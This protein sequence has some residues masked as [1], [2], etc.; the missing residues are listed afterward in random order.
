MSTAAEQLQRLLAFLPQIA[1]GNRHPVAD[2]AARLGVDA[3]TVLKDLR[4]LTER[5]GDPP[6]WVEKVQLYIEAD[7]VSMEATRHFLRPMRLSVDEW[8]AIELGL[9]M[10]RLE[11]APDDRAVIDS[12]LEKVRTLLSQEPEHAGDERA[13]TLG[14]DRH[15]AILPRLREALKSRRRV[16]IAYVKGSGD[17]PDRRTICP[18]SFAVEQ[19]VWYLVAH[20]ERSDDLRIFRLDRVVDL[21]VLDEQF[22]RTND[23]PMDELFA[24]GRAFV[25]DAPEK[26]RVRYSP[27][28]ARWIGEREQGTPNPD[29]SLEVEYPLADPDWAVRHALQ[30]GAEAEVLAPVAIRDAIVERLKQA[31]V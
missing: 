2:V 19:G 4:D 1:D 21:K 10:L 24:D 15:L 13:A 18:F 16:E 8:R 3:G 12:A 28:V 14:A 11:R 31:L 17:A 22:D 6:G 27:R 25:G 26:L 20:C 30:Y 7:Q 29:G 9:A 5:F 23:V